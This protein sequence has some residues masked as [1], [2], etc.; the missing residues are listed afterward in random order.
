MLTDASQQVEHASCV[1]DLGQIEFM[2][3]RPPVRFCSSCA[4]LIVRE[5]ET[6]RGQSRQSLVGPRRESLHNRPLRLVLVEVFKHGVRNPS[7]RQTDRVRAV[8]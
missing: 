3:D 1:D 2:A 5:A 7:Q 4:E 8:P 6:H